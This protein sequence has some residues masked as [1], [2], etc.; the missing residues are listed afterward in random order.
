[1]AAATTDRNTRQR[2]GDRRAFPLAAAASIFAG[3]IV[4]LNAS[5]KLVRG[6]AAT[7][8]KCV[9]VAV[10]RY[11]NST[12][13]ADAV[14]GEA[15]RGI[16]GPFANSASADQIALADVGA[17]CFIVDDQT[18][19]K[20]NGSNTRSLAGRVHDVTPEGVWVNFYL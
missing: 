3:T 16:Y 2:Q 13:A 11:D 10:G 14:S 6:S 9:G 1:M 8:L 18:V 5:G 15:Q 20:T 4:A 7:G 12:G 19:A 17:D